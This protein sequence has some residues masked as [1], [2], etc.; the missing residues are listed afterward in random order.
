LFLKRNYSDQLEDEEHDF[1]RGRNSE[2]IADLI[3]IM[4]FDLTKILTEKFKVALVFNALYNRLN[5][6]NG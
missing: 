1:S 3:K 4:F 5:K 6:H 2:L